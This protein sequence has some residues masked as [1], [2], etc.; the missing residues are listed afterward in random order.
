MADEFETLES[1]DEEEILKI[2]KIQQERKLKDKVFTAIFSWLSL[3][4]KILS[5]HFSALM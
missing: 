1:S 5:K 4:T 2:E 3:Y